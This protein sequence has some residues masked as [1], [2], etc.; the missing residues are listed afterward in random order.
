M[1]AVRVTA[2][3]DGEYD[4]TEV[5]IPPETVDN[6]TSE[7][8]DDKMFKKDVLAWSILQGELKGDCWAG[9]R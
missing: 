2:M 8:T 3:S 6:R 9:S 4:D 1:R 7:V 5:L